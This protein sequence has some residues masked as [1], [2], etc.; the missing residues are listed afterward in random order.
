[1]MKTHW[2]LTALAGALVL[3]L[4]AC[5]TTEAP[6]VSQSPLPEG[7]PELAFIGQTSGDTGEDPVYPTPASVTWDR[8]GAVEILGVGLGNNEGNT[9]DT[10]NGSEIVVTD[11]DTVE[12]VV[13]QVSLKL[14]EKAGSAVS[15][16]KDGAPLATVKSDDAIR[17]ASGW[18]Y[19]FTYVV[20]PGD[21]GEV[22]FR[23]V[24]NDEAL[25]RRT[26]GTDFHT[27]RAFVVFVEREDDPGIQSVGARTYPDVWWANPDNKG[28]VQSFS[29]T[30]TL[31]PADVDRTVNVR[32]ALAEL[33]K[34]DRPVDIA[35]E[36][37]GATVYDK[38]YADSFFVAGGTDELFLSGG[39]FDLPAG[40]TTVKITVSSPEPDSSEGVGE[41]GGDSV[42]LKGINASV[43]IPP[44][45]PFEGCTPGYWRNHSAE[46]PGNQANEW[47]AKYDGETFEFAFDREITV[48]NSARRGPPVEITD[49]TLL[50]A[51]VALGGDVNALAR[52]A[53]A[54]L[55]NAAHPDVNYAYTVD[56]V[57]ELVQEALDGKKPLEYVKDRLETQNEMGCPL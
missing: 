54:A 37:D 16:F 41:Y 11:I 19:E 53:V 48:R 20:E 8:F 29:E 35:I 55:L 25:L 24:V 49:P 7:H 4:A 27:P 10:G 50:Q 39:M 5:Q 14:S 47:P 34:D 9:L 2:K 38:R 17:N 56:E 33:E 42:W 43:E 30:L 23:A 46:A 18:F 57:I 3:L 32:Y 51:V 12:A 22:T 52:H 13:L 26:T 44:P 21:T 31:E 1:M 6:T 45:P 36:I 28:Y 40:A 15:F